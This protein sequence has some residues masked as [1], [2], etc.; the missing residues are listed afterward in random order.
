[1]FEY[2]QCGWKD[3]HGKRCTGRAVAIR[4]L[5]P[6]YGT[7][8]LQYVCEIHANKGDETHNPYSRR[9]GDP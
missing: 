2:G 8:R 5:G 1:M 7:L 9:S 6:T 3:R 4:D